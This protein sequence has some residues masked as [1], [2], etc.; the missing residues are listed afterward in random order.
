MTYPVFPSLPGLAI[1]IKRKPVWR[2][3]IQSAISGKETRIAYMSYPLYQWTLDIGVMRSSGGLTELAQMIGF[4][5]SLQGMAQ[6]FYFQ[7]PEDNQ[8]TNQPFGTGDG[9]TKNFQLVRT[10]GGYSE[11]V[12]APGNGTTPPGGVNIYVNGTYI[13]PGSGWTLG[14]NG[15]ITFA[16]AP[17]AG[18]TI[19]WTGN[20]YFIC[21]L[22]Q[23]NPEFTQELTN[24][25]SAKSISFQS[26]KF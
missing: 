6:P 3:G 14:A 11:P 23:D 22:M 17:A 20:F 5:N 21:R 18:A 19:V 26:I 7:D 25:W 15:L 9:V 12:Q 24:M 8:V 2:T 10:Y 1:G 13:T 16:T 4:I